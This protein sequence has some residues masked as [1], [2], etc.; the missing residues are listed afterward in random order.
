MPTETELIHAFEAGKIAYRNNVLISSNP[1]T[2]RY[3]YEGL[4]W[5]DSW[6]NEKDREEKYK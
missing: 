3:S 2:P 6:R 5:E 1:Y 4:T